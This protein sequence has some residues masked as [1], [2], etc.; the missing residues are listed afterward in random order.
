DDVEVYFATERQDDPN[1]EDV[2]ADQNGAFETVIHPAPRPAGTYEVEAL[3]RDGDGSV[4]ARAT[5]VFTV[6]CSEPTPTESPSVPTPTNSPEPGPSPTRRPPGRDHKGEGPRDRKGHL[7]LDAKV[8]PPGFVVAARGRG[9]PARRTLVLDWSE[10][11]G[12]IEVKTDRLG[13]F[14]AGMLVFPNDMTG[15]R[16]LEVKVRGPRFRRV[17]LRFLVVPPTASPP[18]FSR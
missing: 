14:T 1:Q 2:V 5:S 11:A 3:Q 15:P 13:R 10:G 16:R 12:S 4:T 17:H 7:T 18:G 8:G 9:F 6:P